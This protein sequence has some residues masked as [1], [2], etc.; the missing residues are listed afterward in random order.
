M[1]SPWFKARRAA[2]EAQAKRSRAMEAAAAES[3]AA[4]MALPLAAWAT[5]AA[6]CAL[7]HGL[8]TS[9]GSSFT[10][11]NVGFCGPPWR[12]A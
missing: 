8:S 1:E 7:N 4:S 12:C 11:A 9:V 5:P 10:T 2:G 3:A 6:L